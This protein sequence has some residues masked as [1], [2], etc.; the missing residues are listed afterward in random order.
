LWRHAA[1]H[2]IALG[3]F[4]HLLFGGRERVEQLA[5]LGGRRLPLARLAD[6]A[7]F[8]GG[9]VAQFAKF[10]N[11]GRLLLR[12]WS[13]LRV[14]RRGGICREPQGDHHG[15]AQV[16]E[17]ILSVQAQYNKFE[18]GA[19]P[20]KQCECVGIA[21]GGAAERASPRPRKLA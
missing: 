4:Q 6:K 13:N 10:L 11:A 7:R 8:L 14:R 16:H 17:P 12:R 20:T 5:C 19:L 2:G 3:V 15:L 21:A 9:V 18:R 1:P